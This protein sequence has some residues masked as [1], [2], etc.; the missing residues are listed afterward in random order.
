MLKV[1]HIINDY[2]Q[3]IYKNLT[4]H[5]EPMCA[6]EVF[7]FNRSYFTEYPNFS[8]PTYSLLSNRLSYLFYRIAIPL[9][10]NLIAKSIFE[11]YKKEKH[12]I[13]HSHT[14]FSGGGA[15]LLLKK[16]KNIKYIVT[17]RNSDIHSVWKYYPWYRKY[18]VQILLNASKIICPTPVIKK[19][20][21]KLI[22][23][24]SVNRINKKIVI[25]PNGIDSFWLEDRVQPKII[26]KHPFQLL[27]V[28]EISFNKNIYRLLQLTK[29]NPNIKTLKIVGG[30]K[31]KLLNMVYRKWIKLYAKL[32]SMPVE[33][34]GEIN[35]KNVLKDLYRS[36]DIFIMISKKETFGLTY[37]ESLSQGTP[38]IYTREQGI[39]GL[40][41]TQPVGFGV[42]EID[43]YKIKNSMN[44]I[45][46]NYYELSG[47]SIVQ[48]KK[49]NWTHISRI[50]NNIYKEISYNA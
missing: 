50:M 27:F 44:K 15:G 20:L 2:S 33:W 23:S 36:S 9:K 22:Y 37:I 7:I 16:R 19:K 43:L 1:L 38:I 17:I 21:L 40:F 46:E 28:G 18:G 8:M 42:D 25:I 32:S 11:L 3:S 12:D 45:K 48:S 10:N 29:N 4:N 24:E 30:D 34:L 31:G 49:F 5:L 26:S 6:Q 41:N 35:N 39:D 47:Y 13:I 14:W